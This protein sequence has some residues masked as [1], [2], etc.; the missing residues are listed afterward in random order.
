MERLLECMYRVRLTEEQRLELKRRTRKA[1]LAPRTRDRLEMVRL[2]DAG[3]SI[4]KI[5]EHLGAHEDTV[6]DWIKKFLSAET[7]SDGHTGSGGF[8]ALPDKPHPG[9]RSVMT[10]EMLVGVKEHIRTSGRTWTTRQIADWI[11]AEYGVRLSLGWLR[12]LLKRVDLAYKRTSR[13]LRH[14]QK[15]DEVAEK[16]AELT[17]LEKGGSKACSMSATSI[18]PALR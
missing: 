12:E 16:K 5:A 9:Q 4:P 8:E 6:R 17:A 13:S 18:R 7:P 11:E 2:S 1:G 10:E 14:K 15:P 3:F